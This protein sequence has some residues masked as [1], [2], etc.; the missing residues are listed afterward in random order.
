M[1]T[2]NKANYIGNIKGYAASSI[3][4]ARACT[5]G[6]PLWRIAVAVAIP[7]CVLVAVFAIPDSLGI[8]HDSSVT[9]KDVVANHSRTSLKHSYVHLGDTEFVNTGAKCPWVQNAY[10]FSY[11]NNNRG[12]L[13][14]FAR[15]LGS[16]FASM[17]LAADLD[18]AFV[19]VDPKSDS[20]NCYDK[21]GN[22][23]YVYLGMIMINTW[24]GA[25]KMEYPVYMDES[26]RGSVKKRILADF[27]DK[28]A[29]N[30][31][32]HARLRGSSYIVETASGV[33][34]RE[35]PLAPLVKLEVM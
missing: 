4:Y 16:F 10:W 31:Q 13:E 11:S 9:F 35:A 33:E 3:A 5:A 22:G 23:R 34:F 32:T 7:I 15:G 24:F 2:G 29:K 27:K 21:L 12:S 18:G 6:M 20:A 28:V 1:K 25:V 19:I 30:M 17:N 8:T 26:L 14:K